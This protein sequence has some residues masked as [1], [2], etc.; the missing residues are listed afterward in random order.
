MVSTAT[1][2]LDDSSSLLTSQLLHGS[3]FLPKTVIVTSDEPYPRQ[4]ATAQELKQRL[5][6]I[7]TQSCEILTIQGLGSKNNLHQAFCI[8]L[9]ETQAPL[10]RDINAENFSMLKMVIEE[11]KG[12]FWATQGGGLSAITPDVEL[13]KGLSRTVC[14]ENGRFIFVTLALEDTE[15]TALQNVTNITRVFMRTALALKEPENCDTEYEERDGM[16]FINRAVEDHTLNHDI[17]VR[18]L[19]QQSKIQRFGEGP[20]LTL[21]IT[22]PGLLNTLKFVNDADFMYPLGSDE[23]EI[24]V[25]ASG[26]SFMDILIA[27]G[28]VSSETLGGECAG[29]VRQ[30]GSEVDFQPGDRVCAITLGTYRSYVR[31]KALCVTKVPDDISLHEAAALPIVST[32]AYHALHVVAR[33]THKDSILVHCGAGGTG[34][35]AIQISKLIGAEIFTTVGSEEK[36]KLIV[37]LY[38]IPEDH[39]FYSR[40][41]SFSQG[42][43]RMT[44]GRGVDVILDSLAGEGLIA[45][46]E[47]I[48]PFGR[49]IEIGKKDVFAHGSL[50][51]FPFAR[52]VT[53]SFVDIA[54]MSQERPEMLHG[55]MKEVMSLVEKKKL[56]VPQPL[57]IYGVSEVEKAFRYLQSG[58]NTG[59]VIIEM[60]KDDMVQVSD[61]ESG[62]LVRLVALIM[63]IDRSEY[64]ISVPLRGKRNLRYCGWPRRGWSKHRSLDD[65]PWSKESHSALPLRSQDG[66]R[67]HAVQRAE[68]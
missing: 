39:I 5:E 57:H 42:V 22:S 17:S 9:P 52:N 32:T 1:G 38:G 12:L 20:P 44:R 58:Q 24:E 41:L 63:S 23:I 50:P 27:L 68:R 6:Q 53:F 3:S 10:L 8:F 14:S 26:I 67:P 31:C 56:C 61:F 21:T 35:A 40:D 65:S 15:S 13:V 64:R 7:G 2:I 45:S 59:K 36:K 46:W 43:K 60:R 19:P 47:C 54:G 18:V 4:I 49:F 48:A 37:N 28:R 55:L 11:A 62:R 25:R 66:G 16:L 29:I 33:M 34:Q 30:A 51:M